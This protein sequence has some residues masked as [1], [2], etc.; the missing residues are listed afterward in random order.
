METVWLA[1]NKTG[2][3]PDS[4]EIAKAMFTDAEYLQVIKCAKQQYN[5]RKIA[6][7]EAKQAIIKENQAMKDLKAKREANNKPTVTADTPKV[8]S[9]D[10]IRYLQLL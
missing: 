8:K 6:E 1:H 4:D 3:P 10:L 5:A 9:K 7:E 2:T